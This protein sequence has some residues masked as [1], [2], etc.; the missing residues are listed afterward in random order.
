MADETMNRGLSANLDLL[1]G[2]AVLMVLFDHLCR[3]FYLDHA[4]GIAV[5]DI[6]MFGVLLFLCTHPWC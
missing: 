4:W 1:R 3:H 6:G 5:V 2:S